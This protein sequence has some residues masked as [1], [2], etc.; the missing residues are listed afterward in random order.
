MVTFLLFT[1]ISYKCLKQIIGSSCTTSS[2]C[3]GCTVAAASRCVIAEPPYL[4]SPPT[5][6]DGKSFSV[7]VNVPISFSWSAYSST[8]TSV[9]VTSSSL[10]TSAVLTTTLTGNRH[11]Q[12]LRWTPTLADVGVY[13]ITLGCSDSSG[14]SCVGQ[15]SFSVNVGTY[16]LELLGLY[17]IYFSFSSVKPFCGVGDISPPNCDP[18]SK[19]C[20]CVCKSAGK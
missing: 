19:S 17:H 9:T 7:D 15:S 14:Q 20:T 11:N 18:K 6:E 10:P 2:D 3:T 8:A 5:P 16:I 12:T 1:Y 13:V 4:V